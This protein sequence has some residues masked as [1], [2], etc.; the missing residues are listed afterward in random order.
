MVFPLYVFDAYGTLFDVHSAVARHRVLVGSQAERLSELWRTKQLEY[1]WTRSLMGAYRDF[2]ALTRDA[3]DFAAA[4]C[5]G[6]SAE[7]REKLLEAY[8]TL[9]PY[10]DAAPVLAAL[11]A[12]GAKTVILSNGTTAGLERAVHSAGLAD[13]LDPSLSADALRVFKTAPAV[14]RMVCDRYGFRPEQISFQSS[15]RWDVAG[16]AKFGFRTVWINR[17]GAPDEYLD[18][19]PTLIA[20]SLAALLDA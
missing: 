1:A 8:E 13:L 3:L 20:A 19:P 14:Y 16:A 6:I 11:R 4:R 5:G 17:S 18:L 10:A 2:D 9:D 12:Q 7:A 15:N